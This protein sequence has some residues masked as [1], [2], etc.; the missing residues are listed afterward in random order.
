MEVVEIA[1]LLVISS[2]DASDGIKMPIFALLTTT[3]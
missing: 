3:K 2:R 1:L